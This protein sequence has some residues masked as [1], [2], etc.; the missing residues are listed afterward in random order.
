KKVLKSKTGPT[1]GF[2][3]AVPPDKLSILRVVSAVDNFP[4]SQFSGC[5]MG[6]KECD[7]RKPCLL[8]DAWL[9][10]KNQMHHLLADSTIADLALKSQ[11]FGTG[12]R[13]RVTLSK[14]MR[15]L[16]T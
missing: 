12:K 13:K 15:S 5:L 10:A 1:G 14:S 4:G 6:F 8:H 11:R 9:A 16:F 3:L 7:D 2:V